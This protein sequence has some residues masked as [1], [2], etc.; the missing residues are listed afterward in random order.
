MIL[1]VSSA[2]AL[3]L[4][5]RPRPTAL[6]RPRPAAERE[7]STTT[8]W[9]SSAPY[10]F[11]RLGV[12]LSPPARSAGSS[13]GAAVGAWLVVQHGLGIPLLVT[14]AVVVVGGLAMVASGREEPLPAPHSNHTL[15]PPPAAGPPPLV[16]HRLQQKKPATALR[17]DRQLGGGT[18]QFRRTVPHLHAHP[19]PHQPLY[20][21]RTP[22]VRDMPY[23][24]GY[25]LRH[26]QF[27]GVRRLRQ[28]P[29]LQQRA[30]DTADVAGRVLTGGE[31]HAVLDGRGAAQRSRRVHHVREVDDDSR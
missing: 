29:L 15:L 9:S 17:R 6:L 11:V 22:P 10:G 1:Y 13:A 5:N 20:Q 28:L 8:A 24:V 19:R 31:A 18:R 16:R 3:P 21:D 14:A 4:T 25:Q 12:S 27:H 2:W 30:D 7:V 23:D 26:A